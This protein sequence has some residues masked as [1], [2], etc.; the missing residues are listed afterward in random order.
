MY[1]IFD[2]ESADNTEVE[3]VLSGFATK[4]EAE[5]FLK[6]LDKETQKDSYVAEVIEEFDGVDVN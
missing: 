1:G 5:H 3:A 4:E 6:T 2:S